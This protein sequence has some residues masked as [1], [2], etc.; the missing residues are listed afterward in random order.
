[1]KLLLRA[2]KVYCAH[3]VCTTWAHKRS[4][5]VF[6]CRGDYKASDM[7]RYGG[8]P[9]FSPGCQRELTNG[10]SANL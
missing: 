7:H 2:V 1:M 6:V 4:A 5:G 10:R 8:I 9:T 3:C